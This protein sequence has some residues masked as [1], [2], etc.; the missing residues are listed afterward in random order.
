MRSLHS[1]HLASYVFLSWRTVEAMG[2]LCTGRPEERQVVS[3]AV[4]NKHRRQGRGGTTD[5]SN[6]AEERAF[7]CT[8]QFKPAPLRPPHPSALPHLP[9][10]PLTRA[11]LQW[12]GSYFCTATVNAILSQRMIWTHLQMERNTVYFRGE[13]EGTLKGPQTWPRSKITSTNRALLKKKK[14]RKVTCH[15]CYSALLS[16]FIDGSLKDSHPPSAWEWF[17]KADNRRKKSR[18]SILHH[19]F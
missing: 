1:C 14:K 10:L 9:Q 7:C 17:Y 5:I 8:T 2:E 11:L 15:C 3:A 13:K 16:G 18:G 6:R 12:Q 4:R 19:F